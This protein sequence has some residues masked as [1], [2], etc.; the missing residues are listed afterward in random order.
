MF[1]DTNLR[2]VYFG[3]DRLVVSGGISA[4]LPARICDVRWQHGDLPSVERV[5][6]VTQQAVVMWLE[7]KLKGRTLFTILSWI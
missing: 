4:A 1:Q 7:R 6:L 5:W 3:A 2:A